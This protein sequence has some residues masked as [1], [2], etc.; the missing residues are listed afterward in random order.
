MK[1]AFLTLLLLAII[2]RTIARPQYK[3]VD[4]RLYEDEG[5]AVDA[6][7]EVI[8]EKPPEGHHHHHHHK[9]MAKSNRL[10]RLKRYLR[11]L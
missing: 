10:D 1:L 5:V 6:V 2:S 4:Y 7:F 3:D 9:K 8:T 11:N